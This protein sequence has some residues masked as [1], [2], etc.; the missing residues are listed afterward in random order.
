MQQTL[1][2]LTQAARET[3]CTLVL[4]TMR[5]GGE[6]GEI[7]TVL[8]SPK[9]YPLSVP[10]AAARKYSGRVP[11]DVPEAWERRFKDQQTRTSCKT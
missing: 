5:A 1:L 3:N 7:G 8:K 2:E 4:C 11:H 9:L 6:K 10:R